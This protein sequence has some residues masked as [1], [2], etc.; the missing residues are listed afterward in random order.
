MKDLKAPPATLA[1]RQGI[2]EKDI[3][4]CDMYLMFSIPPEDILLHSHATAM[5]VADRRRKA[6]DMLASR[7]LKSYIDSRSI[8]LRNWYFDEGENGEREELPT[9]VNE[10]FEQLNP[11]LIQEMFNIAKN[12]NSPNYADMMK[13]WFAKVM[14]DTQMDR[15]A[16]RPK[17]YLPA[18]CR[19][20]AYRGWVEGNT[21]VLCRKCKAFKFAN[22]N[23]QNLTLETLI[24]EKDVQV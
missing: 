22:D 5:S 16:E 19:E 12:P 7:E 17:R 6:R 14:K 23:G 18:T 4:F 2:N 21:E 1:M 9:T 15:V 10:A 3:M 8:Q 24:E 13:T 20:C 11:Q